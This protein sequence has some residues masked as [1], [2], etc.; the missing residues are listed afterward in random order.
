VLWAPPAGSDGACSPNACI[1]GVKYTLF[2]F[3]I[4]RSMRQEEAIASSSCNC[5]LVSS[6]KSSLNIQHKNAPFWGRTI[7]FFLEMGLG[8]PRPLR[9]REGTP[10]ARSLGALGPRQT[11]L[12]GMTYP[13]CPLKLKSGY[14]LDFYLF[15]YIFYLIYLYLPR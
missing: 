15:T 8:P 11:R 3:I 6:V 9:R 1:L 2:T 13:L 10:P 14:A 7:N 5:V 12:R 4:W